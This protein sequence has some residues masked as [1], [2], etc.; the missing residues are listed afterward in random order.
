MHSYTI[1][2][3][4]DGAGNAI[5]YCYIAEGFSFYGFIFGIFWL[6]YNALW[7]EA[8]Q[9]ALL[10]ILIRELVMASVLTPTLS[11][12]LYFTISIFVGMLGRDWIQKDLKN[13]GFQISDVIIASSESDA[14]FRHLSILNTSNNV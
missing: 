2:E 3:K 11:S 6:L 13:H 7:K 9:L 12:L 1:Y 10:A 14:E 5:E 8:V 4:R